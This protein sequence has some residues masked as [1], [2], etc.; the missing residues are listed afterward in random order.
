MLKH[1]SFFIGLEKRVNIEKALIYRLFAR[2]KKKYCSF[3]KKKQK[4]GCILLEI[5]I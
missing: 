4:N 5:Y 2:V 1:M 3:D